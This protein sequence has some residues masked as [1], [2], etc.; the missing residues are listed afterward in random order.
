MINKISNLIITC[1]KNG[2]TELLGTL[3]MIKS[4]LQRAEK[5]G[6][7]WDPIE[8]LLGMITSRKDSVSQYEAAGRSDL[9]FKEKFE[10]SVIE[11]LL[12]P[13]PTE[14]EMKLGIEEEIKNLGR[15]AELKDTKQILGKLKPLFPGLS[16]K[17]VSDVIKSYVNRS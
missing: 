17:L 15:P 5:S 6:K 10:I 11:T 14:E 16:G 1:T 12:P 7:Q 2:E 3:R 4:E 13:L 8:V 9:A